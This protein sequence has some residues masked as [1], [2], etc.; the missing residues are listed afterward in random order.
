MLFGSPGGGG[1]SNPTAVPLSPPPPSKP[2]EPAVPT[3][4]PATFRYTVTMP[5]IISEAFLYS[6]LNT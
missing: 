3:V 4:K 5:D 2:E 6:N 1:G